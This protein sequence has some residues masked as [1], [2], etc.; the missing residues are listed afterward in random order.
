MT[1][2]GKQLRLGE[3]LFDTLILPPLRLL[4]LAA[5]RKI[6]AFT[7]RA[8]NVYALGSLPEVFGGAGYGWR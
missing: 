1:V 2:Q 6:A 3:F 8:E 5:A 4:S 7:R